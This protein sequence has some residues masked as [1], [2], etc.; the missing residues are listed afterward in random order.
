MIGGNVTGVIQTLVNR[1]DTI[2][3]NKHTWTDAQSLKGWLDLMSESSRYIDF[4]AK[5]EDSDH[6]FICDYTALNAGITAGNARMVVGGNTYD[7]I[8][9]DNP[10]GMNR[11]WE[12]YLK[13]R[14]F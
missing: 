8:Y 14:D 7:I 9:M 10:M 12:I 11:Q 3:Q 1:K 2:G 13:R 4:K 5:V 6:I